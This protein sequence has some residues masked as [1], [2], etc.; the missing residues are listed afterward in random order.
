MVL[1]LARACR[2][3]YE[4]ISGVVGSLTVLNMAFGGPRW[5]SVSAARPCGRF[6]PSPP[7][8]RIVP[9]DLTPSPLS[10]V[11]HLGEIHVLLPLVRLRFAICRMRRGFRQTADAAVTLRVHGGHSCARDLNVSSLVMCFQRVAAPVTTPGCQQCCSS[12][13]VLLPMG[14]PILVNR[15]K[16]NSRGLRGCRPLFFRILWTIPP[17]FSSIRSDSVVVMS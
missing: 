8:L 10:P 7:V 17:R 9:T 3:S 12:L 5:A 15:K 13:C 4:Q 6:L 1:Q 14:L 2:K 16:K 11:S